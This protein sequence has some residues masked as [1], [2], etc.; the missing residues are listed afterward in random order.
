MPLDRTGRLLEGRECLLLWGLCYR[1]PAVQRE[2]TDRDA[3]ASLP[4]GAAQLRTLMGVQAS[5][6]CRNKWWGMVRAGWGG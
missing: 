2:R 6:G 3:Q 1:C 5:P 4:A